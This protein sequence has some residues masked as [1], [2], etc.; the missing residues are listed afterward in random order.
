VAAHETLVA[1]PRDAGAKVD[2]VTTYHLV[3]EATLGLTAF[4]FI[5]RYLNDN[6]LL[7]GFVDGYTHIHHDEQRHIATAS[8]TS[9]RP[10]RMRTSPS[11]YGPSCTSCCPR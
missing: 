2:F 5:S 8:G 7:P 3:I 1:N 11:E 6:D 4:E 10:P 9:A